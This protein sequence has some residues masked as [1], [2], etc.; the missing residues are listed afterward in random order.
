M[1]PVRKV[2]IHC[3]GRLGGPEDR[4]LLESLGANDRTLAEATGPA[5][6]R[7]GK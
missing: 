5:L 7:L 4:A 6:R 2:A 1:I 3:L